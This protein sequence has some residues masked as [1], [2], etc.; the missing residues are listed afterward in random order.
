MEEKRYKKNYIACWT[1][2]NRS[3]DNIGLVFEKYQFAVCLCM[4]LTRPFTSTGK[5]ESD[6]EWSMESKT[7][8]PR[9]VELDTFG[10]IS[11]SKSS[12]GLDSSDL[13]TISFSLDCLLDLYCLL[14]SSSSSS[15]SLF[16]WTAFLLEVV[17][18]D[19]DTFM[20]SVNIILLFLKLKMII[21][22]LF[23]L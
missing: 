22:I 3:E 20:W 19:L 1:R 16:N 17:H 11:R 5:K 15:S 6:W 2:F 9:I 7:R 13:S 8:I 4:Y 21:Q 14:S 18:F 10:R 12:I 23:L